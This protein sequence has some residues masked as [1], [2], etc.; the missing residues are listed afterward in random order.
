MPSEILEIYIVPNCSISLAFLRL[1]FCFVWI[2]EG[3][4][5]GGGVGGAYFQDLT[6]I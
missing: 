2:G 3:G 4:G 1:L 6:V 5:G